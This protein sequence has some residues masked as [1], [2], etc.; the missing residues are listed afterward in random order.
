MMQQLEADRE[1][2]TKSPQKSPNRI[3][4]NA[5]K[6]PPLSDLIAK[7]TSSASSVRLSDYLVLLLSSINFTLFLAR[8]LRIIH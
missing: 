4:P 8:K 1:K 2:Q 7:T 5:K 6:P 3:S